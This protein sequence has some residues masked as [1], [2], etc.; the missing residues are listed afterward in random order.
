MPETTDKLNGLEIRPTDNG[1]R[2]CDVESPQVPRPLD[3]SE[4]AAIIEKAGGGNGDA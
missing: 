4:I 1:L 2:E 3:A